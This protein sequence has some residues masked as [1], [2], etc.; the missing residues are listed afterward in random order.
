MVRGST[1]FI[2]PDLKGTG[3]YFRCLW[4]ERLKGGITSMAA[5]IESAV[6]WVALGKNDLGPRSFFNLYDFYCL[7]YGQS[8]RNRLYLTSNGQK[9]L[10]PFILMSLNTDPFIFSSLT[11]IL[12][13]VHARTK[14]YF[15]GCIKLRLTDLS[16]LDFLIVQHLFIPLSHDSLGSVW[17]KYWYLFVHLKLSAQQIQNF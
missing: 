1:R 14:S 13:P 2:I 12:C 10:I 5:A 8:K 3:H 7:C 4:S 6:A 9:L 11:K 15:T 17:W 16:M